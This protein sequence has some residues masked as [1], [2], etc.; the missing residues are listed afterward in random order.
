MLTMATKGNELKQSIVE[1]QSAKSEENKLRVHKA[2]KEL[3]LVETKSKSRCSLGLSYWQKK[4]LQNLSAQ[5]L[6]KRNMA[7]VPKRIN[8]N[9]NDVHASIATSTIKMKKENDG[10]NKQLSRRC[11]SQHQN[12]RLA[13]H[14]C[15]STIPLMPLPWNSSSGMINYPPWIYF[16]PWKRHNFLHH[17]RVLPNPYTIISYIFSC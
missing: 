3:P 11:A 1:S 5:E 4:E 17:E 13:H 16:D 14:P 7:W 9:K 2:Q 8:Q 12:L 6:R 15:F 10:S